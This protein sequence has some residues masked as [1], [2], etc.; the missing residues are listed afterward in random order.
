MGLQILLGRV[1][2]A[3]H[4]MASSVVRQSYARALD[5]GESVD[6]RPRVVGMLFGAWGATF[7]H[8]DVGGAMRYVDALV[9]E[10]DA[11]PDP[12]MLGWVRY[13]QAATSFAQGDMLRADALLDEIFG[14]GAA[15]G[16]VIE[17]GLDITTVALTHRV[18]VNW[19]L[20]RI[21]DAVA[22]A[23]RFRIAAETA[24][25]WEL[26]MTLMASCCLFIQ[27]RDREQTVHHGE[28]LRTLGTEAGLPTSVAWAD[29]YLG[30]AL[31]DRGETAAGIEA[32]RR[33]L[34][35]YLATD[36]RTGHPGY[37]RW[38]ATAQCAAG[39]PVAAME[40]ITEAE[41][42]LPQERND[43][44]AI[45]TARGEILEVAPDS[46]R[47]GES[48]ELCYQQA[49]AAARALGSVTAELVAARRLARL[50]RIQG[51]VDAPRRMLE[52]LLA[53]IDGGQGVREIEAAIAA[54]QGSPEEKE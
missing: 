31:A 22:T 10:W 7:S 40:T 37:L 3:T 38:I 34:A 36:Q 26:A 9:R 42:A 53:R 5:L 51:D 28:R 50:L 32:M 54:I 48:A 43:V 39:D 17:F 6:D 30:W 1:A 15:A 19:H 41:S 33:G 18:L 46:G 8:G 24:S 27:M 23:E 47:L 44:P 21:D 14:A 45:L 2:S 16:E 12:G 35:G 29:L 49:V 20:G 11:A 4:G 25:A 13:A 52:P